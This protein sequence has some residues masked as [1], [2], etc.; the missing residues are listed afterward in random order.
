MPKNQGKTLF[1]LC[2]QIINARN[3]PCPL[4]VPAPTQRYGCPKLL[5]E[6]SRDRSLLYKPDR[7]TK[8][9]LHLSTIDSSFLEINYFREKA[10]DTG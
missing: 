4:R 5:I 6:G 7:E 10:L 3:R 2:L 1:S 9:C 8:I